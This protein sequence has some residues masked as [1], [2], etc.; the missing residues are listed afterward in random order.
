MATSYRIHIKKVQQSLIEVQRN[1]IQINDILDMRREEFRDD[2]LFNMVEG[3]RYIN[4]LLED[5]VNILKRKSLHHLLELNH[6]VLCGTS[7]QKRKDFLEHITI[8]TDRFYRQQEFSISH[9]RQWAKK[10]AHETPWKQAAGAY[11]HMISQP[12]LFLEGNHRTGALL[13][14]SI[15]V[16]SGLPPFVLSVA[17][18][19]GYFNPS[20]LAKSTNKD[21][22]GRYYKLPKLRKKFVQFLKDYAQYELLK[23][24]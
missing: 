11:I 24:Y 1:F 9:M 3:Y 10:H 21:V 22:F 2:I 7:K 20:S 17:N 18:A 4:M 19:K 6:I 23:K 5:E 16:Q 8:T 12:Q 14:S 13:M 15:L